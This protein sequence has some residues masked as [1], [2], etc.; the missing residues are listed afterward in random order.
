MSENATP[1]RDA[2]TAWAAV[3]VSW[4]LRGLALFVLLGALGLHDEL[5][6]RAR[7]PL[8]L[9]GLCRAPD[10]TGGR[11]YAGRRRRCNPRRVRDARRRGDRVRGRCAGSRDR[12]RRGLPRGDGGLARARPRPAAVRTVA[13]RRRMRGCARAQGEPPRPRVR[14]LLGSRGLQLARS[15]R[16]RSDRRRA[17]R[18]LALRARRGRT[19]LSVPPPPRDGGVA[20]R[21]LGLADRA[22]AGRRARAA[23]RRRASAS[24]RGPR[25]RIRF[26]GRGR[27]CCSRQA[28]RP[29]RSSTPTAARSVRG[30]P[31][32]S[33]AP[34]T[35]STTGRA[36]ERARQPLRGR[37][38]GRR[39]R[40][41]RLP[42]AHG[43]LRPGDRRRAAR[44]LRVRA[45]PRRQ[46]LPVP[47]RASRGGVAARAHGAPD[48][49][50][51]GRRARA[52]G[53]RPRLL[54]GGAG[55]R[56][57]GHESLRRARCGS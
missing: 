56:A 41:G 9:V 52:R 3:A 39:G 22:H 40:S 12:G 8:R 35:R 33:S 36:N 11:G 5:R 25:A 19:D 21:R 51:P 55:R 14:S 15:R 16:R 2:V 45:R 37:G 47:L 42:S 17:D 7:V 24:R 44:R 28:V 6:A 1:P 18:R 29:R 23:S 53:G 30:R 57:Q 32:R 54:P 27:C 50:R 48:A 38:G 49:A 46:R 34:P 43:P 4:T 26:V 10:R 13:R 31:A 20:D